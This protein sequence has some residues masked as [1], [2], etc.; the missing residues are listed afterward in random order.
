MYI[1]FCH[2]KFSTRNVN[3]IMISKY[4]GT[5]SLYF[6]CDKFERTWTAINIFIL[7]TKRITKL[8]DKTYI[9]FIVF[10]VKTNLRIFPSVVRFSVT[11]NT[12]SHLWT[13]KTASSVLLCTKE[14]HP[15]DN[16]VLHLPVSSLSVLDWPEITQL[17]SVPKHHATKTYGGS[18][19]KD[20][21]VNFKLRPF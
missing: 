14:M 18:E 21:L 1:R 16:V 17:V 10:R 7:I 5:V 9:V 12:F 20:R 4:H 11:L 2:F 19:S 8:W 15:M 6:V 13:R 3:E